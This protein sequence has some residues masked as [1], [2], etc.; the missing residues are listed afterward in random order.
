MREAS[1]RHERGQVHVF[2]LRF[3]RHGQPG[4]RKMDQSP[5]RWKKTTDSGRSVVLD[6]QDRLG[7]AGADDRIVAVDTGGDEAVVVEKEIVGPLV[8]LG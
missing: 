1:G 6:G 4:G 8:R 5:V 3:Q 7:I 2:G